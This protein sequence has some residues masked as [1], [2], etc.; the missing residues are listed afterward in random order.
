MTYLA[1]FGVFEILVVMIIVIEVARREGNV[2]GTA[3]LSHEHLLP[4]HLR[5]LR[6][7]SQIGDCK[8]HL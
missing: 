7:R 3:H 8:I 6:V 5:L 4:L 1:T 2:V